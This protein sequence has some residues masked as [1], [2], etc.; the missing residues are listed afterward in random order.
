M[1]FLVQ[2]YAYGYGD[3][4]GKDVTAARKA[5]DIQSAE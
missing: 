5:A 4:T 2:G 3:G 1:A